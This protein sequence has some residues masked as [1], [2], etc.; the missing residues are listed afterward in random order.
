VFNILG[1]RVRTVTSGTLAAGPH[2][3]SW[4]GCDG[5]GR[6]AASGVY[7]YQLTTGDHTA[8]KRLTLIR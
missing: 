2:S 1:Q 5:N 8:T 3:I 7:I 4:N 6:R